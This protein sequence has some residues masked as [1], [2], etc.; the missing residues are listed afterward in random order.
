MGYDGKILARAR[1]RLAE[2]RRQHSEALTVRRAEVSLRA[3]GVFKLDAEL[4]RLMA[5][6]AADALRKGTDAG[7]AV[8]SAQEQ[9]ARLLERRAELLAKAG[10]PA[11]YLDERYDCPACRDSGYVLGRPCACL[12]A[13][14]QEETVRDL[15]SLLKLSGQSFERFDLDYYDRTPNPETGLSPYQ[16][17]RN[18][19]SLCRDYAEDFNAASLNLLF[20]GSTGLGKTFLSAAIAGVVSE[21]GFSV[22]YDSAVS[23]MEAFE[24]QKFDRGGDNAE[25]VAARVRRYMDCDLL[26]LDDLG[27][28]M[29]TQFTQSALYAL[30]NGRLLSG[31]RT[32]IT[33]NLRDDELHRRYSP[34]I[35]SRL[36]GEY[37][38]LAFDGCDIRKLK[39]ERGL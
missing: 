26:I 4:T 24:R 29:T 14:C 27:T 31:G 1:D 19:L 28:E 18:V 9:S 11:D 34:Q 3:P 33:T 10:L 16:T 15:S 2:R 39:R 23:I 6:L 35:V 38:V 8:L 5:T 22:V 37:L 32:I 7:A 13:Q 36:E 12:D 20:R 30:V 17:M 21:K 25:A